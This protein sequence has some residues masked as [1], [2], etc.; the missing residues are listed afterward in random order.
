MAG[1]VNFLVAEDEPLEIEIIRV[2]ESTHHAF[3]AIK[4]EGCS[5]S[6]FIV[7]MMAAWIKKKGRY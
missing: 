6:D 2:R 4:P 5:D 1:L 7:E 3:N